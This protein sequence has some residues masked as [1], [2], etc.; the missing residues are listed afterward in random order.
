MKKQMLE[1]KNKKSAFTLAPVQVNLVLD[2]DMA[3]LLGDFILDAHP[4]NPAILALGHQLQNII[5]LDPVER[6]MAMTNDQ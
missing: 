1:L 5:P 3:V 4:V 2:L 6:K